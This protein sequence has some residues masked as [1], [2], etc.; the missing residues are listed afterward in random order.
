[1]CP[2]AFFVVCC[3]ISSENPGSLPFKMNYF[4]GYNNLQNKIHKTW[5]MVLFSYSDIIKQKVFEE[6]INL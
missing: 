6:N 2:I 1:M 5:S 4:E 3:Y